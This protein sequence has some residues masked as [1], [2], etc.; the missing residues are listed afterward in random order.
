VRNLVAAFT[1]RILLRAYPRRSRLRQS[2]AQASL[3]TSWESQH[4]PMLEFARFVM[5]LNSEFLHRRSRAAPQ[6]TKCRCVTLL[7]VGILVEGT[8]SEGVSEESP[9]MGLK[10]AGSGWFDFKVRNREVVDSRTPNQ[11]T[12]G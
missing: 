5:N 1:V 2:K 4:A 10:C 7:A 11:H 9:G 8:P 6:R 12:G 3:R